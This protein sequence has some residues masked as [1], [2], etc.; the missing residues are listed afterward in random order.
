VVCDHRGEIEQ[1]YSKG[2]V[3]DLSEASA[4]RW[5]RRGR[6]VPASEQPP[7]PETATLPEADE[8]AVLDP[9]AKDK[10]HGSRARHRPKRRADQQ[11]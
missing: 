1:Q 2:Q 3:A 8:T 5:I 9:A 11:D 10:A 6:A 7:P 4:E